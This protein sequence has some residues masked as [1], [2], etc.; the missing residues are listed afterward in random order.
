LETSGSRG[1]GAGTPWAVEAGK[2]TLTLPGFLSWDRSF[3]LEL[4]QNSPR[5]TIPSFLETPKPGASE[6]TNCSAKLQQLSS[7]ETTT[8]SGI[9][10]YK[11]LSVGFIGIGIYCYFFWAGRVQVE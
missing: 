6:P 8:N 11:Q 10:S 5:A 3:L 7:L 9:L 2:V 1:T 4:E